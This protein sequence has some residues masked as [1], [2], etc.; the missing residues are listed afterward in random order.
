MGQ[1]SRAN[2]AAR[3][4]SLPKRFLHGS[5]FAVELRAGGGDAS[6]VA[7]VEPIEHE[8]E[9]PR[10]GAASASAASGPLWCRTRRNDICRVSPPAKRILC[11][12]YLGTNF[13][14]S[15]AVLR[16]LGECS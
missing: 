11:L 5:R 3:R 9:G 1:A 16:A 7:R 6:Q 14:V 4:G 8:E 15:E 13:A 2:A 12:Q 10:P